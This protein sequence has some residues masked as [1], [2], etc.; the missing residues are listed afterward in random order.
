VPPNKPLPYKSVVELSAF[1]VIVF[2]DADV[3]TDNLLDT[4]TLSL[5]N[6]LPEK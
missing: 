6:E 5:N 3:F 2:N 1:T 4:D